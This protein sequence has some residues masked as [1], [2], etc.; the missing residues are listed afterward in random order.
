[1]SHQGPAGAS[2]RCSRDDNSGGLQTCREEPVQ[3]EAP[4]EGPA[5]EEP[6]DGVDTLA[7]GVADGFV[8]SDWGKQVIQKRQETDAEY[9]G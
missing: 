2:A 7:S 4:T 6:V 3:G 9:A 8:G 1:M 5:A